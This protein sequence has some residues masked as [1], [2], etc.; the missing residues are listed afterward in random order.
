MEEP[1][2]LDAIHHIK[3]K[4]KELNKAHFL[5]NQNQGNSNSKYALS[6]M[7]SFGSKYPLSVS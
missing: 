1:N 4:C 6:V 7:P 3:N 2:G 5:K